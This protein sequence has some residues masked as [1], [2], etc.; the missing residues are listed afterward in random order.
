VELH[1]IW[2][3]NVGVIGILLSYIVFCSRRKFRSRK[4][5]SN[6]E[7]KTTEVDTTYHK[8]DLSKINTEDN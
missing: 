8:L 4:P 7:P 1:G 3:G 6:P 2:C 5:Q